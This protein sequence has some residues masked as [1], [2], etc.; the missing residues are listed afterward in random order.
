V[1]EQAV[2]SDQDR[3]NIKGVYYHDQ[4]NQRDKALQEQE[5]HNIR[6]LR[7]MAFHPPVPGHTHTHTHMHTHTHTHT[8]VVAGGETAC[9]DAHKLSCT[10]KVKG[11]CERQGVPDT[12]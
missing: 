3:V 8:Q 4:C 11:A 6:K 12:R 5:S 9:M 1:C 2:F 7:E 10:R